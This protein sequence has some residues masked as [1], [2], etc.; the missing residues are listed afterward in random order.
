MLHSGLVSITFRQLTPAAIVELVCR[1]GLRGIEWGGDVH[2]PHGDLARAKEVRQLTEQAGLTVP[3]YGSYYRAG[4]SEDEGLPFAKVLASAVELGTPLIR[5]W[6][7]AAGSDVTD[8]EAHAPIVADLRRIAE[9]AARAGVRVAAE[10]HGNTL[11]DTNAAADRL[12]REVAHPNF[13]SYWQPLTDMSDAVCLE[14]LAALRPRLAHVHV[15]QWR[16]YRDRQPLAEGRE[17]WAK[18]FQSAA[19]APGDRYAMLEFV[20]DDAPE[21]FLGDAATLKSLLAAHD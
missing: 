1:A 2:V 5:I 10:F 8:E 11:N 18:F 16:T 9:L 17:R 4:R 3:A 7:G 13:Y 6:A 19:A 21:Y 15:F 14:G 12:L 20:R